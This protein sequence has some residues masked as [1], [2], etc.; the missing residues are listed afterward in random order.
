MKFRFEKR[1]FVPF[2]VCFLCFFGRTML[3]NSDFC[4][5]IAV[6]MGELYVYD[7]EFIL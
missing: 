2:F 5:R 3:K 1:S 7:G 4:G 6:M